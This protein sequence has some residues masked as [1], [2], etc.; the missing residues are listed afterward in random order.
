MNTGGKLDEC[1]D[2]LF[3]VIVGATE[4]TGGGFGKIAGGM[5]GISIFL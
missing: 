3:K 1:A 2:A 4:T 5:R